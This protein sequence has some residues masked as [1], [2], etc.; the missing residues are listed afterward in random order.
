MFIFY[1]IMF[2]LFGYIVSVI[3]IYILSDFVRKTKLTKKPELTTNSL[4]MIKFII[5]S[6]GSVITG[7]ILI[8]ILFTMRNVFTS[9]N[10]NVNTHGCENVQVDNV[11][12]V[13]S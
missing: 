5:I 10:V 13:I 8:V 2:G 6:P 1:Q 4:Q 7:V 11:Y 9:A 3:Y 12:S